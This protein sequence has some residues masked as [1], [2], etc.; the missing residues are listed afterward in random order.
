MTK[1]HPRLA[2]VPSEADGNQMVAVLVPAGWMQDIRDKLDRLLLRTGDGPLPPKPAPPPGDDL[3]KAWLD[4]KG[5]ADYAGVNV[6]TVRRWVRAGKLTVYAT[7]GGRPRFKRDDVDRMM[8]TIPAPSSSTEEDR[9][10]AEARARLH[11]DDE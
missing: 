9:E 3:S 1:R 8:A 7:P 5:V 11:A 2:P 10:I 4:F 6:K